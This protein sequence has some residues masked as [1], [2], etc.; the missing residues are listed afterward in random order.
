MVAFSKKAG[1]RSEGFQKTKEMVLG[2]NYLKKIKRRLKTKTMQNTHW[3]F[4][5]Q[6]FQYSH[7]LE[8][9]ETSSYLLSVTPKFWRFSFFSSHVK[10]MYCRHMA[11]YI[12]NPS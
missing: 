10:H 9:L 3:I 7:N 12:L 6:N 4:H 8:E 1:D 11:D 2:T 5:F